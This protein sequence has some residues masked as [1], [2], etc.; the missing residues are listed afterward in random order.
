MLS[1][2]QS[3][4]SAWAHASAVTM[5]SLPFGDW[6]SG[7]AETAFRIASASAFLNAILG[8]H[9]E[10]SSTAVPLMRRSTLVAVARATSARRTTACIGVFSV[11]A[12]TA[13]RLK[14]AHPVP[15]ASIAVPSATLAAKRTSVRR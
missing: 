11:T 14:P 4:E 8:T 12:H 3:F 7:S 10:S 1:D 6:Y 2:G 13:F 5:R 9:L 15:P